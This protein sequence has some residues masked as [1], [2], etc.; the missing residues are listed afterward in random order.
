MVLYSMLSYITGRVK[1]YHNIIATDPFQFIFESNCVGS[2]VRLYLIKSFMF[3]LTK[4]L[5]SN[6]QMGHHVFVY[7]CR[8]TVAI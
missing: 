1:S 7:S 8:W 3:T 6:A 2:A 4:N 5:S